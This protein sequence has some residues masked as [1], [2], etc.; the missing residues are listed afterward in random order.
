MGFCPRQTAH[1]NKFKSKTVGASATGKGIL[2]EVGGHRL[3]DVSLPR[4]IPAGFV[5][6]P[7]SLAHLSSNGE[8]VKN[9]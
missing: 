9:E 2:P 1:F 5:F 7:P 8:E 4:L 3:N 6:T